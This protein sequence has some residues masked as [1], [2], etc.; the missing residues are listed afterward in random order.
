VRS[1]NKPARNGAWRADA[2]YLRSKNESP[3]DVLTVQLPI[4]PNASLTKFEPSETPPN[5]PSEL[6]R[7]VTA[8]KKYLEQRQYDAMGYRLAVEAL[9]FDPNGKLLLQKRGP[10]CRDEVGN[11]ECLGGQVAGEDLIDCTIA[12]VR[13]LVGNDVRIQ[14]DELLDVQPARF[15]E[16]HGPED[17]IVVGYLCRLIEGTPRPVNPRKTASLH[18]MDLSELHATPDNTLSRSTSRHR[19]IYRLKF[20][21]NP[22][23]SHPVRAT[24]VQH[25]LQ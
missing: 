21:M 8:L 17:W 20:R 1:R 9:I 7:T 19:D 23:F 2:R 15:M 18:W 16:R 10:E 6:L 4:A 12:R 11:F 3:T 13:E 5:A 22:Y 14:V 24:R 25:G